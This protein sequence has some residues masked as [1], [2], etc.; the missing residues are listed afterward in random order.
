MKELTD[1]TG[2]TTSAWVVQKASIIVDACFGD[3]A[4]IDT[5]LIQHGL[6][7]VASPQK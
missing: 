2:D 5:R 3:T 1:N 7:L 4:S 6:H